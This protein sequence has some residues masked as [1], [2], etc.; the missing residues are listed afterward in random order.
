MN[1]IKFG[2]GFTQELQYLFQ[3]QEVTATS[4]IYIFQWGGGTFLPTMCPSVESHTCTS[5]HAQVYRR[6]PV[7]RVSQ[8]H[9]YPHPHPIPGGQK[10]SN[11]PIVLCGAD[12]CRG[13]IPHGFRHPPGLRVWS[14]VNPKGPRCLVEG[15]TGGEVVFG[16]LRR[17]E[18]I[19]DKRQNNNAQAGV[20]GSMQE[21]P[22]IRQSQRPQCPRWKPGHSGLFFEHQGNKYK[23]AQSSCNISQ[24]SIY[25]SISI[26]LLLN[27]HCLAQQI[28]PRDRK[29]PSAQRVCKVINCLPS[30]T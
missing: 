23:L 1:I 13:N 10:H 11:I 30:K 4:E 7:C 27:R 3:P 6:G 26:C 8:S 28:P 22:I 16:G 12:G 2:D 17:R 9:H 15:R 25:V 29:G 18:C 24:W 19:L 5:L 21:H 14:R 20:A